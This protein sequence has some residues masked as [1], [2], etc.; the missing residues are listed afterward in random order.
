MMQK[1]NHFPPPAADLEA[2]PRR[3]GRRELLQAAAAGLGMAPLM[4]GAAKAQGAGDA[5]VFA[6]GF[7]PAG[8]PLFAWGSGA[9][10]GALQ[11]DV[12]TPGRDAE[13]R[14]NAV[15]WDRVPRGRWIEVAGT[16]IDQQLTAAVQALSP[17]WD[18]GSLW[19]AESGPGFNLFQ[20]W[21]GFCVDPR[22]DRFWFLGGGHSDGYN[23]GLYRFDCQRMQWSVE[24]PPSA[25]AQM[26]AAYLSNGSSTNYPDSAAAAVANFNANN[27]AGTTAGP[28]VPAENGPFYDQVPF[29]GKPTA[30]HT[31][32]G[33]AYAPE[34]GARGSIFMHARRLWR[35]DLASGRWEWKRLVNDRVRGNPASPNATGVVEIH[36]AESALGLWDE[37]RGRVL[38]SA[39]GSLGAGAFA[40]R[41]DTQAWEPWGGS[42]GLNFNHAAQS[43]HGRIVTA[44]QPP[45]SDSSVGRGRYWRLDLDSGQMLQDYVQ[46]GGGLGLS[47]FV[48]AS[49]FY[50][51][52]AMV[53]VPPRNRFWVCTRASASA[54]VGDM[55]WL[56][57]DPSTTPWTLSRLSF[58]NP[59]PVARRVIAGR[60]RWMPNLN[61][62]L[63]WD[64]CFV[65][66]FLFRF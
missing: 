52:A 19:G 65:N 56:E 21:S 66:A 34:V 18:R 2:S 39:S 6:D 41:W 55:Q 11:G 60:L 14:V 13:G 37:V 8:E 4:H 27:P 24:C 30:R 7:E 5:G 48:S 47:A 1:S 28:L 45:F 62:V 15:S 25:R 9:D 33:L 57:L 59:H 63:V 54:G 49:T 16:R 53:F 51:G 12:W 29:D 38:C 17:G 22:R 50:D 61:A 58:P 64:H 42:Y 31:Y 26:S 44:F 23:N 43:R 35:F 10:S 46:L 36:A 20:S 40:F 32:E 3:L